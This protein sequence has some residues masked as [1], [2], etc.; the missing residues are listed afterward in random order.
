MNLLSIRAKKEVKQWNQILA[1]LS[2]IFTHA[3]TKRLPRNSP[4]ALIQTSAKPRKCHA[5]PRSRHSFNARI[6]N[7]KQPFLCKHKGLFFIA[8]SAL[9]SLLSRR[10]LDDCSNT[11][12]SYCTATLT[13][14][15][16][17]LLWYSPCFLWLKSVFFRYF[18]SCYFYLPEFLAPFWHRKGADYTYKLELD[19]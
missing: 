7:K 13:A 2:S 9:I 11:S 5:F 18:S 8:Y 4:E 15:E 10:L 12:S 17:C 14:S 1:P 16:S 19:C 3:D 6:F